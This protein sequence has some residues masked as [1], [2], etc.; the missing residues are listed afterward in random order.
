MTRPDPRPLLILITAGHPSYRGYLVR[1]LGILYRVHLVTSVEPE[2]ELPYIVS[3]SVLPSTDAESVRAAVRAV[4]ARHPVAGVMSWGEEHLLQSALAAE[5]LDLP[6]S[7]A[8]A[9]RSCQD[10]FATRT[11]LAARGLAQPAF[12]LVG[13]VDGALAAAEKLGFPVVLKPRA[14][15][16]SQGV[17]LVQDAAE[18]V[19]EFGVTQAVELPYRPAFDDVVLV[20]EYLTGPEISIDAAVYGGVVTPVF[21]ARKEIGFAPYFE[22]TGHQ[23]SGADPLLADPGLGRLLTD[24]HAALGY[25]DGWT[26]TELK[27]TDRGPKVIEVNARLG[28]DLIPYLGTLATGIDPAAVVAAIACG[29]KPTVVPTVARVAGIRFFYPPRNDSLVES[30]DVDRTALPAEVDLVVPLVAPG[31]VVSPPRR[32]LIDGRV[33]Y[34]IAVADTAQAVRCALDGAQGALRLRVREQA[35]GNRR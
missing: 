18:L 23:V 2:W 29:T 32:G 26:H 12:A 24:V 4:A 28:G 16:A 17:V 14:A 31:D 21:L 9:V 10:K 3:A 20:E 6:G 8:A 22:E 30:V 13:D 5:D 19:D 27:L 25:T 7:R 15:A 11:A 33:A 1:S 35:P 34:A